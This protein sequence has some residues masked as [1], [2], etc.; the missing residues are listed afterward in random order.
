LLGPSG[1]EGGWGAELI[2]SR[3]P[4]RKP[5]LARRRG[6]GV[7]DSSRPSVVAAPAG[8]S[9]SMPW[10]SHRDAA[11]SPRARPEEPGS[12]VR[13]GL[14]AAPALLRGAEG[15]APNGPKTT[16][17][18]APS[19]STSARNPPIRLR[20]DVHPREPS[21]ASLMPASSALPVLL[22]PRDSSSS[23]HVTR[24]GLPPTASLVKGNF[25]GRYS[26]P[27]EGISQGGSSE[28]TYLFVG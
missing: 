3:A 13:A 2:G 7:L 5:F 11:P 12:G 9:A 17:P 24:S 1:L 19:A 28:P 25:P 8:L 23:A 14:G 20:Q 26:V 27:N 21:P 15:A 18:T 10:G 22:G 4:E 6:A 16:A